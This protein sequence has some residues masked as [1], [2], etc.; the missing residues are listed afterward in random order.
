M[1]AHYEDMLSLYGVEVGVRQAR[2][3]LGWYL[4]RHA[5]GLPAEQRAAVMTSFDTRVVIEGLRQAFLH[6]AGASAE[7]L[8]HEHD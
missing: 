3:H 5:K 7:R 4:D 8:L 6:Q 2:K 1:V